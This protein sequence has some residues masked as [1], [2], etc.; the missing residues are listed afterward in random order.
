MGFDST[1]LGYS[2]HRPDLHRPGGEIPLIGHQR[3]RPIQQRLGIIADL[4]QQ[5]PVRPGPQ[6]AAFHLQG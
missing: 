1:N 6:P 3:H 5:D 2:L 4:E